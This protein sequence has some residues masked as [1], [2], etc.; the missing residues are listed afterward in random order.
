MRDGSR[1]SSSNRPDRTHRPGAGDW[2]GERSEDELDAYLEP[3]VASLRE[4]GVRLGLP[5]LAE[6][7]I[8]ALR[9]ALGELNRVPR[10]DAVWAGWA[11]HNATIAKLFG[12]CSARLARDPAD[13]VARN[14]LRGLD[15]KHG[16]NNFGLPYLA[17][18]VE[19]DVHAV[20]DAVKT[21]EF[22]ALAVGLDMTPHLLDALAGV[23]RAALAELARTEWR[24][25]VAR[26]VLE[27]GEDFEPA[28]RA[29]APERRRYYDWPAGDSGPPS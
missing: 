22:G 14:A 23:D 27:D 5:E 19:Q 10:D 3:N 15:L 9:V 13:V 1:S 2:G 24:A 4:E 20:L 26:R 18:S 7:G 25:E 21:A 29:V 8:A 16:P 12:Y 28:V 6:Q 17:W 11:N